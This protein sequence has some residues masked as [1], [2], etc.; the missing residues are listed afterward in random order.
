[1]NDSTKG[2]YDMILG[3]DLT[4]EIRLNIKL[5]EQVTKADDGPFKGSTTSMVDLGWYVFKDLN[6]EKITPQKLFTN[7]YVEA[8]YESEHV[9]TATKWLCVTLD[10]KYEKADLH[11]VMETQCQYLT[12]TQRNGFI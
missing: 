12:M 10:A 5:S 11:K 2:R 4:T 3:R 7:A 9:H 8:V 6:T 1:M